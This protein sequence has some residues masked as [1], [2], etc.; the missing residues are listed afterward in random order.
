MLLVAGSHA[1]FTRRLILPPK[2]TAPPTSSTDLNNQL[3]SFPTSSLLITLCICTAQDPSPCKGIHVKPAKA[4]RRLKS[5][6]HDRSRY[7]DMPA[8]VR[9]RIFMFAL[10]VSGDMKVRWQAGPSRRALKPVMFVDSVVE[11]EV[12]AVNQLQYACKQLRRETAGLEIKFNRIRLGRHP[13]SRGAICDS[14]FIFTKNCSDARRLWHKHILLD[15]LQDA[16]RNKPEL[17][18]PLI[19]IQHHLRPIFELQGLCNTFPHLRVTLHVPGFSIQH[20]NKKIAIPRL[21]ILHGLSLIWIFKKPSFDHLDPSENVRAIIE[22]RAQDVIGVN[23]DQ[24]MSRSLK[25][26]NILFFPQD[27]LL[28]E[29]SFRTSFDRWQNRNPLQSVGDGGTCLALAR[30]WS[31]GGV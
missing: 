4:A 16:K 10:S 2:Y 14:L 31:V 7:L 20:T 22:R 18:D 21:M 1:S 24:L 30:E 19:W 13:R 6:A 12:V 5:S 17:D 29:E 11:D 25:S 3:S 27:S 26:P 9:N 15:P 28:D 8:E 23:L